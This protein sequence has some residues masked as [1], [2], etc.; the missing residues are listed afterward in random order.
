MAA[1]SSLGSSLYEIMGQYPS[2]RSFAP[3]SPILGDSE[4]DPDL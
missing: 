1:F 2:Q 4:Y 3:K